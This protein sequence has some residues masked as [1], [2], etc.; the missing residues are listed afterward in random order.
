MNSV[1]IT[2]YNFLPTSLDRGSIEN[3]RDKIYMY[4]MWNCTSL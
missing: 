2:L 4:C 1:D 3:V